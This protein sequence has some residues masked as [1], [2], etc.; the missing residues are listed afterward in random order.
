MSP[1]DQFHDYFHAR[2]AD[3]TPSTTP[4]GTIVERGRRRHRRRNV[5]RIGALGGVMALTGVVATQGFRGDDPAKVDTAA[6]RVVPSDLEW[7]TVTPESSISHGQVAVLASDG[8]IYG[9]SSAPATS[10]DDASAYSERTLYRSTNDRD[11]EQVTLPG[12]MTASGLA[13]GGDRIYA[14]G[15]APAGG[16]LERVSLAAASAGSSDWTASDLD[17][18]LAERRADSGLPVTVTGT[19]VAVTGDTVV[20]SVSTRAVGVDLADVVLDGRTTWEPLEATEAG[21]VVV[22]ASCLSTGTDSGADGDDPA[23]G[24]PIGADGTPATSSSVVGGSDE[25]AIDAQRDAEVVR[26]DDAPVDP[27]CRTPQ[28]LPWSEL[29]ATPAQQRELVGETVTLASTADAP[30]EQ[31]HT[32]PGAATVSLQSDGA[33][34]WLV[35]DDRGSDVANLHLWHAPDGRT[36]TSVGEPASGTVVAEGIMA[37]RASV[38]VAESGVTEVPSALTVLAAGS[39]HWERHE[40]PLPAEAVGGPGLVA[41]GPLGLAV[42]VFGD[43]MGDQWVVHSRDLLSYSMVPIEG[44]G[45]RTYVQG[46][47]VT[48]DAITVRLTD[49]T[50]IEVDDLRT[51]G[52]VKLFVGAPA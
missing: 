13:A 17:L 39:L 36:W 25:A 32:V 44:L 29:D 33:G 3:V 19:R 50:G 11:W 9:L 28:V 47:T 4:V 7:T 2:S 51:P 41:L 40:V 22:P 26:D 12:A 14:V 31:V 38:A 42:T 10:G 46:L 23:Y 30:F 5:A 45:E 8:S 27:A 48:A 49:R 43:G 35:L 52:T 15:T 16:G 6:Q 24:G 1:D 37:G 34:I 21:M 18:D 20:A